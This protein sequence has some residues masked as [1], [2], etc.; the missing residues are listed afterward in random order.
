MKAYIKL[1]TLEYPLYQGDIRLEHPEIGEIFVC[2]DTYAEVLH[3]NPPDVEDCTEIFFPKQPE[4]IN[5]QWTTVWGVRN[6]TPEEIEMAKKLSEQSKSRFK[7]D[8]NKSGS[9]PD[10]IG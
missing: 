6:I 9:A 2:P 10:V 3:T 5:G 8:I 1:S 7:P 4:L